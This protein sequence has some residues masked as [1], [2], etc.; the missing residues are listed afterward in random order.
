MMLEDAR[1]PLS[2]EK[3]VENLFRPT[4]IAGMM[5]SVVISV[6][7]LAHRVDPG[8]G[9]AY[10]VC[11]TFLVVWEAIQS[12]RVLKHSQPGRYSRLRFRSTEWI[13][14][15][16]L[17]KLVSYAESGP[18]QLAVDVGRWLHNLATFF[19]TGYVLA[20]GL[21]TVL[22]QLSILLAQDLYVLEVHPSELRPPSVSSQFYLWLTR[23][24]SAV[25][26]GAAL[27]RIM[28]CFFWGGLILVICTGFARY[29]IPYLFPDRPPAISGIVLNVMAYFLLGLVLIS[30][31]YYSVLRARWQLEEVEIADHI[32]SR[33]AVL[34]AVFLVVVITIALIL[35]NGYSVGLPQAIAL[36]VNTVV[37]VLVYTALLAMSV[38]IFVLNLIVSL[39]LR[40]EKPVMEAPDPAALAA[41][42][43]AGPAPGPGLPIWGMLRDVLLW[44]VLLG[45]VIYS[46]YSFL[47]DR[48][49]LLR[50]LFTGGPLAWLR[51]LAARLFGLSRRAAS[52]ARRGVQQQIRRLFS[53]ERYR[54]PW[55]YVSLSS[56]S[57]RQLILYFYLSIVR[58]AG[59]RDIARRPWQTPYEYST[60]L[61]SALPE[62]EADVA[63]LTEAF[64]TARYSPQSVAPEKANLVKRSWRRI[65]HALRRWR[66]RT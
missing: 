40:Q 50:G 53:P 46:F 65:R 60:R 7:A 24:R 21:L 17:L 23:P 11:F 16:L 33:W 22:W 10:L 15:M 1:R 54:S 5:A 44:T 32:G 6:V 12:E 29:D 36:A 47:G 19:D 48:R 39:V 31:G 38:L 4:A 66:L 56:L 51:R 20:G 57:A 41:P 62:R 3:W 61:R 42:L 27:R 63:A 43:S 28:V 52:R 9:G 64:V 49:Q 8:W 18:G 35:P 45:I 14:A 37:R 25:N 34:T 55:R 59:E 30:Q 13:I 2:L 58:R 26:R